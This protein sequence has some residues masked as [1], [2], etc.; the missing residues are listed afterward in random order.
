MSCTF[1]YILLPWLFAWEAEAGSSKGT[2][3]V[4]TFKDKSFSPGDS[5]HPYLEPFGLISC[6]RC[7]CTETG[8]VKC[9]S[10]KCPVLKCQNLVTNSQQCCPRCAGEPRS[11]AGLRAPA[12]FCKYNG[13]VYQTGETFANHNLFPSKQANQCV[14][15]TCSNGNIFCALKTCQPL[16]CSS[17]VSIPD[18]CCLV[19]KDSVIDMKSALFGDGQ[20]QLNRGV[21]HSLDHCSGV[22]LRGRSV[23]STPTTARDFLQGLNLHTLHLKGATKTTV[24]ILLQRKNQQACVYSGKTYSHGDVWHPVLGKVLECILC[25]CRDGLQECKRITCPSHYPCQHPLK[26][27]GK[28]CKTCPEQKVENRTECF[29]GQDSNNILVYKFEPSPDAHLEDTVRMIAIERQGAPE[30]EVQ[31]WKTVGGVLQL[32]ETGDLQRKDLIEHP[33]SYVLLSTLD[34]ETWKKFKDDEDKQ[35]DSPKSCDNGIKELQHLSV[36]LI[37]CAY[38]TNADD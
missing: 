6:M 26:A 22:H 36:H 3:V 14:M 21:R 32:M 35:K 12:T 11:P 31:V 2:G 30:V 8:H 5:W 10:I 1:I 27:E 28:C 18:T 4:C 23:H 13:S 17:P 20:Q 24:K 7:V 25:T 38:W 33:E 34:E 9:N 15:C 37:D 29:L 16:Q 19:C